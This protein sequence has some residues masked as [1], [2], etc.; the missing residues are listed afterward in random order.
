MYSLFLLHGDEI[1]M[2]SER[3]IYTHTHIRREKMMEKEEKEDEEEK[4]GEKEEEEEFPK[5][6]KSNERDNDIL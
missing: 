4:G 6:W 5:S 1:S 3:N 2:K